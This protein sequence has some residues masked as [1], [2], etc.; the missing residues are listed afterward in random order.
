MMS[1]LTS[2]HLDRDPSLPTVLSQVHRGSKAQLS[3]TRIP[4]AIS[5][6]EIGDRDLDGSAPKVAPGDYLDIALLVIA[7]VGLS[8]FLTVGFGAGLSLYAGMT[9]AS[10]NFVEG[11]GCVFLWTLASIS[12]VTS[13]RA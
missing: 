13:R 4:S 3:V 2:S 12:C 6:Q 5:R 8:L 10:P 11:C 1:R 9:F 7:R